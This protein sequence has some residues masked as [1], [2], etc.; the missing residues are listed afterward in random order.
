MYG[1]FSWFGREGLN[2]GF[3]GGT[4]YSACLPSCGC[5]RPDCDVR[6]WRRER[7]NLK[8]AVIRAASGRPAGIR[9]HNGRSAPHLGV[10]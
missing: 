10:V 4:G 9:R 3:E 5:S 7:R 2:D 6:F 1:R 8:R